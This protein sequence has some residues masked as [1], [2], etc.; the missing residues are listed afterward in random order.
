[1]KFRILILLCLLTP[2]LHAQVNPENLNFPPI[3]WKST[4]PANCPFP[5]SKEITIITLARM[6]TYILE[7]N[8]ITGP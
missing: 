4:P 5:V 7:S 3:A 2:R 8:E 6:H 1:M